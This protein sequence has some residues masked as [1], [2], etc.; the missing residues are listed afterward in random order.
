MR[1]PFVS[2]RL[3]GPV[4]NTLIVGAVLYIVLPRLDE[5]DQSV[6]AIRN[7]DPLWVCVA[8]V[9]F[10]WGM[11]LMAMQLNA[12]ALKPLRFWIT[13]KVQMAA[14]FVNKLVPSGLGLVLLNSYYLKKSKH[15][16]TQVASVIG[17]S[18]ATSATAFMALV[19]CALIASDK[20]SLRTIGSSSH[21]FIILGMAALFLGIVA[22][23][24]WFHAPWRKKLQNG[25]RQMRS[26]LY[27]YRHRKI[28]MMVAILG[29]GAATLTSVVALFACAA[30]LDIHISLAQALVVY[31]LGN[32]IGNFIPTP[33]GIGGV[34]AG[35]YGGL[36]VVGL[37]QGQALSVVMLYRFITYWLAMIPGLAFF[38]SLKNDVLKGFTVKNAKK[39]HL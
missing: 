38:V 1:I 6:A 12:I 17:V 13:Y 9:V 5:L 22:T 24:L 3:K 11:P 14:L 26:Q 28:D 34:D 15:N 18:A 30:A 7:A 2:L 25:W 31:T 4:L 23:V 37:S 29:N 20:T 21:P 36:V 27:T 10:F 32:V 16:N 33:G 8:L 35:L 19:A 39:S